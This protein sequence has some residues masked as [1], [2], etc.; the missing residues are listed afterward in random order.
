M[1]LAAMLAF[2][3]ATLALA[4]CGD[5]IINQTVATVTTPPTDPAAPA[6]ATVHVGDMFSEGPTLVA[7]DQLHLWA[8]DAIGDLEWTG[9]G[10]REATATGEISEG[11]SGQE[12]LIPTHVTASGIGQCAGATVYT[13][14]TYVFHGQRQTAEFNGSSCNFT[15]A[16]GA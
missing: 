7:P 11:E 5:K 14:L 12:R 8:S 3:L 1:R 15:A 9:W 16:A 13:R 6:G 10:S 2:G 4:G